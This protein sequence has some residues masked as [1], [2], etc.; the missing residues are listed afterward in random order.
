MSMRTI[1]PSRDPAEPREGSARPELPD[2]RTVDL[3]GPVAY[4]EWGPASGAPSGGPTF[5]REM[6]DPPIVLVGNSMGGALSLLQAAYEPTSAA[7]SAR[8]GWSRRGSGS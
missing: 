7:G 1:D 6:A 8:S 5:V 3:D 4:R 2:L